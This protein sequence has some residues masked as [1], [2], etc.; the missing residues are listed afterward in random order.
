LISGHIPNIVAGL[1]STGRYDGT[2]RLRLAIGLPVRD[3]DGLSTFLRD[4][5]DP[6]S[7]AFH[8]FLTPGQF[9]VRFGP[10]VADYEAVQEFA[11][12]N[13]LAVRHPYPNRTV[14]DVEGSVADIEKALHIK[15]LVYDHPDE[16]RTF[17]APDTE[18]TVDCAARILHIAGLDNSSPPHPNYSSHP[19]DKSGAVHGQ[20]GAVNAQSGSGP[21]GLYWGTD[22]RAAYVPGV[23]LDGAG[24]K[25]GLLEFDAYFP[26]DPVQYEADAG[27]PPNIHLSNI[28]IAGFAGPPGPRNGEV[29]LDIEMVMAM[30]PGISEIFVYEA[31]NSPTVFAA[32]ADDMLNTMAT[33]DLANQLSSSWTFPVDSLTDQIFVQMQAQGQSFFSASGDSGAYP[34]GKIPSPND[35]T[36][37]TLVGGTT[38][39]TSG[40]GGPWESE[41]VW[42]YFNQGIGTNASSGGFSS[43]VIIPTWQSGV[44]MANNGGSTSFRNLPDVALTADNIFIV[45]D[46]GQSSGASGTSAAAPL[47]AAFTALVNEQGLLAGRRPVGF[48]NPA[49]YAIG[50]GPLYSSAF[51]D[52]VTGNNTNLV[53]SN[54]FFAVPGYDLC[55]GWGTPTGSALINIL[56]PVA[57]GPVLSVV[58]T[59]ITGGNGNGIIDFDEC[60]N[61]TVTLTN[62]GT[63]AATALEGVLLSTTPGVIVGQPNTTF[64][65]LPTNTSAS[66]VLPFTISTEPN[67]VCGTPVTLTLILKSTQ[68]VQTNTIVLPS[69]SLGAPVSFASSTVTP[70]PVSASGASS[71]VIVSGLEAAGHVT[72]STYITS[73]ED[74][75]LV[76][77]LTAPNGVSVVLSENNGGEGVNYGV[78]C[79]QD[80]ETTFD[81]AATNSITQ[82]LAPYVGSFQ[83]QE[84]LSTYDLFSGTN[85]N[86]IWTLTVID[87]LS[88]NP[89]SLNCWSLNISPEVCLDGGGECPGAD[90]SLTMAAIPNVV[91]VNNNLVFDLTVS[92]AGPSAATNVVITQT[93]PPGVGFVTTSNNPVVSVSQSGSTLNLSLGTIP[94]Y[95]IATVDV[96]TIPT[97]PGLAT[98]VATVGSATTD[99]NPNNNSA[100]ATANVTLPGADLAVSIT[101]SPAS[102]LQGSLLTYAI[103]VTNNGPSIATQVTL[104]NTLPPDVNLISTFT[105]QGSISSDGTVAEIGTLAPGSSA[106]VTLVV[107]P[108]TTGNLTASASA[109]LSPLEVDP[110]TGNNTAS[111][112]VTVGPS[113]DL[114]VSGY[115]SPLTI[116]SGAVY[117]NIATVINN[118]PSLATG[119]LFSQTIPGGAAFVSSSAPGV[120]VTNASINWT[121]G[122]MNSGTNL[123]ITNVFTAPALL[124]GI[125]SVSLASTLTVFGQPG[126]QNT[127]NNV[128]VLQALVEPPTITIVP[129]SAV[130]LSGSSDGAIAPGETVQVELN[131]QNTGNINTTNVVA[132]IQTTG[133]V[134]LPSP[135]VV[136]YGQLAAG[137]PPVGRQ[138]SFTATATNGGTVVATLQLTD[139]PANLGTVAFTFYM[140]V[141]ATFW[142][143]NPI[144]IPASQFVPE[145]DS[146]PANPYPSLLTVSDVT[147]FVSQVTV[148]LSNLSHSYP[149]DIAML[150]VG[151]EGQNVALMVNAGADALEG[152]VNQT[153]VLDSTASNTLPAFGQIVAGTYQPA[154]YTP[155]YSLSNAPAA[156][157][158]SDLAVFNGI[159]PNGV[160][161]LYAYDTAQGD[162][163]ILSNGWAVTITTITPVNQEAD[164]SA[165]IIVSTNRLTLGDS[166]AFVMSVTNNGPNPASAYLTNV[167]P[168]GMSFVSTSLPQANYTQNG[169]TFVYSVGTLGAGGGVSITNIL[170]AT[171]AGVQTDT[172][173]ASSTLPDPNLVNNTATATVTVSM[174]FADIAAGITAAPDPAVVGGNLVYTLLVTNLG[175]SNAFSV[176]GSFPLTG[177]SYVSNSI[178][179]GSFNLAQ[180]AVGGAPTLI[181]D[182]GTVLTGQIATAVLTAAPQAL[183][184]LTNIWTVSTTDQDPNLANNSITAIIPVVNPSPLIVAG[185]AV[186]LTQGGNFSNGGINS[187]ETVT[188]SFALNNAGTAPTTNLTATLQGNA[189]LTPVTAS[190]N[191]GTII[192]GGSGAESYAFT[193]QG[194]PGATV[195]ATLS[196]VNNGSPLGSVSFAFLIPTTTNYSQTGQIIIPEYGPGQPYPSQI[197]VSGVAGLVD[198]VTVTLN[199]FTHTFPHDVNVLLADPAGQEM[200]LMSHVGGAYSVT[201]LTLTFADSATQT[202]PAGQLSSGTYLPTAVTPLNPLPGLSAAP[203]V[204]ALAS[205]DGANPNGDWSLYVFDDTQGNSGV[206]ANGWSLGLTCVKTVNPASLLAAGMV[207][208]PDPVFIGDYLSYLVTVTNLGP[209]NATNVVLTDTLP[210][211]AVFNSATLSQGTNIVSGATVT[212]N[213]GVIAAGATATATIRIIV[214]ES[215][216]VL[217]TA[218]VSSASADLYLA[219]SFTANTTI[220][221]P[222]PI[223][224]LDATNL[225]SGLQLTLK[226]QADL[227]HP[228]VHRPD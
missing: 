32:L 74:V 3:S 128:A 212:C 221:L 115:F 148:T 18:P 110:I 46:D 166:A 144:Q 53:S 220:V 50:K 163:G 185:S 68:L 133:G 119:V 168:A 44:S 55:T 96:I 121:I 211:G 71:T 118:G 181:C 141:V 29:A 45:S 72:V 47:W 171:A 90:L 139:G 1:R 136:S 143:T 51:H 225:P 209:D 111:V 109:S 75:G 80:E 159:S 59:A 122:S 30:A 160:W 161:S 203:S 106:L 177:L 107:S 180:A 228:G 63:S 95:G 192:P 97:V 26:L 64:P 216:D 87:E 155:S 125:S 175:P 40:K 88:G 198:G 105:S 17:F 52:I 219:D 174:P 73:A 184:Q 117:T 170:M 83:P 120:V 208:A 149:H 78:S 199:G 98:S 20:S 210:A 67:F 11:R 134:T 54:A 137:A 48:L 215:G 158:S 140:P 126:D 169:Q 130:L 182:F 62:A 6:N 147:G 92:N 173:T 28:P 131:L 41:E 61:L 21:N 66:S 193:A 218:T 69:G 202:L 89:S 183:G 204:S 33:D 10:S 191:Y 99:P 213:F 86:G 123:S 179:Q 196:L 206:I 214:E 189:N 104:E 164:M 37:I 82:G 23:T 132:T 103:D 94:V 197:Q 31:T 151:P 5:Y 15:L 7:P 27:L 227:W 226:G 81:D 79:S 2:N 93:L 101:A 77:L 135:T 114:A 186:L 4:V 102:L 217:N 56:A 127:N 157:Y 91:L 142:N 8:Q 14:L 76:L 178:S 200:Y 35:N 129:V 145:P 194:S 43:N 13:G 222:A 38:V 207:H 100:S 16:A 57:K 224:L 190:Q 167:I 65:P 112:T 188:V 205:F 153:I 9:A 42:S 70:I 108:T 24:Q 223:S 165:N 34:P 49:I 116:L 124:P 19:I 60:N 154:D 39:F 187:T 84:P 138:F 36:N 85:L 152:M 201:N 156:P 113:A 150:L 58:S 22:F 172:V 25:V 195:T 146:G 162:S 176:V 12:K